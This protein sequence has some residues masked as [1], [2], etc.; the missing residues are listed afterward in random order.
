MVTTKQKSTKYTK[1]IEKEVKAYYYYRKTSTLK[2]EVSLE[3]RKKMKLQ[4]S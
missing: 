2:V 3:R 1:D 4:N